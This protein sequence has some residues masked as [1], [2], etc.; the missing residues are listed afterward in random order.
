ML[1]CERLWAQVSPGGPASI[2]AR[3]L[4]TSRESASS[5]QPTGPGPVSQ[6][7]SACWAFPP[8]WLLSGCT[9]LVT[10]QRS[11]SQ[12]R[13]GVT[14]RWCHLT[15][16]PSSPFRPHPSLGE[17]TLHSQ[18]LVGGTG[19]GKRAVP[20]C[21]TLSDRR[22]RCLPDALRFLFLFSPLFCS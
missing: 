8:C 10:A 9:L 12:R 19:R 22:S 3:G 16:V 17:S 11:R 20:A 15:A 13:A 2:T 4:L 1:L 21:V 7:P 14:S 18:G 6:G 5:A